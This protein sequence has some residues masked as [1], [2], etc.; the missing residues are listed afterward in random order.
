MLENNIILFSNFNNKETE[1]PSYLSYLSPLK[2]IIAR[3][4]VLRRIKKKNLKI[5]GI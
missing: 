5:K 2:N 3:E 1:W 4:R